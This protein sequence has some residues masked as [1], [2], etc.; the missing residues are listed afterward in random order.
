MVRSRVENRFGCAFVLMRHRANVA[1]GLARSAG[2]LA[3][4]VALC[5]ALGMFPLSGCGVSSSEVDS[6]TASSTVSTCNVL[7]DQKESFLVPVDPKSPLT[8]RIDSKFSRE[9]QSKITN[10]I[11]TWNSFSQKMNSTKVFLAEVVELDTSDA[12]QSDGDCDFSGGNSN[13]LTII[14]QNSAVRWDAYKLDSSNPAVTIRCQSGEDL[15]KQ[16]ILINTRFV[17]PVQLQSIALHELGH[18]LGLDHSC[19]GA[20]TKTRSQPAV[21]DGSALER[22]NSAQLLGQLSASSRFASCSNVTVGHPYR[23]AVM[24]PVLSLPS[25]LSETPETK[26]SLR[27]NDEMR[28]GCI[29]HFGLKLRTEM[30]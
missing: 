23:D 1:G 14:K 2:G 25:K 13:V 30:R 19:T 11:Q 5:L 26:E 7:D 16:A 3:R 9:E 21:S 12:P 4:S 29:Y 18:S 6:T 28:A 22:E 17:K 24:F 10:A 20:V 15:L 27:S 8:V